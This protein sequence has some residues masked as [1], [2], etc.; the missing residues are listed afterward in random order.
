MAIPYPACD[1]VRYK[2]FPAVKLSKDDKKPRKYFQ[3]AGSGVFLYRPPGFDPDASTI[4]FVEGEKKG[5][6]GTQDGLNV[7]ALGGIWNFSQAAEGEAPRL[8]DGLEKIEWKA[9]TV[10]LV[11]DADFQGNPSVRHAVYRLGTMLQE[12]GAKV[13]IVRLPGDT[14]LDDYLCTHSTEAFCGL[15]L[16]SLEDKIF[17]DAQVKEHGL[18]RSLQSGALSM[19]EFLRKEIPSTP[20]ILRPIIRPGTL[21]QVYSERGIG[22]TMFALSL[23]VA[24]THKLPIG[25]WQVEQPAG[26]LFVD[27]EMPSREFQERLQRLTT[28]LSAPLAP[29]TIISA[30]LME[31]D[32][33]PRITLTNPDWRKALYSYLQDGTYQLLILDNLAALS[34]GLDENSKQD[35]DD[36]NQWLLS[37]RFLGVAT[38]FVHHAGK[39]GNPRGTSG[40]ED[41]L[42]VSLRLAHPKD[43]LEENGADFNVSFEKARS[44]YGQDAA[45]F[46]FRIVPSTGTGLTW[47]VSD[48]EGGTMAVVIAM[49]GNGWLSTDI[50]KVLD[51]SKQR[52]SKIKLKAIA[53]GLLKKE[54]KSMV[55]TDAGRLEFGGVEIE[56]F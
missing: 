25:K 31:R 27:A 33:W 22:K 26:V 53:D 6:K 43:Y 47:S 9:K 29:L 24:V 5:L 37:L 52:V 2:L 13:G 50:A 1:F 41:A 11:P 38:V 12:K 44:V 23:A 10:E 54:G 14:K 7:A 21:A 55:F 48:L 39:S 35:W 19:G 49:L 32:G 30:E 40:R 4:R 36:I 51:I 45:P 56:G 15:P 18:I 46:R 20:Y 3:P 17:R 16:L 28:G 34:P 8:I 42:D